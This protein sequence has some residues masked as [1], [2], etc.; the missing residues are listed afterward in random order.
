[1]AYKAH[2]G[3]RVRNARELKGMSIDVLAAKANLEADIL[4]KIETTKDTPSF[5]VVVMIARALDVK[6]GS[7]ID[8][9]DERGPV[10]S[11]KHDIEQSFQNSNSKHNRS[12]NYF[13]MSQSKPGRH[14]E[15]YVISFEPCVE[16]DFV[17]SSH[18]G[19]EFIFVLEGAVEIYYGTETYT[20]QSGDSIYYDSIIS[21]D[22]HSL[23]GEAAK[24]LAV[25]YTPV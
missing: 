8:E 1:M 19:E 17:L 11:R 3:D 20:L 4:L 13:S 18:R 22:I 5:E 10:I 7:L 24:I 25:I 12:M 15:S 6:L 14:L 23:R 21:H 16:A 2:V 9:H